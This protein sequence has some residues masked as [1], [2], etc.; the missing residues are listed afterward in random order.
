MS[1]A[2]ERISEL[3]VRLLKQEASEEEIAELESWKQA[4][5][6]NAAMLEAML[7]EG[8][9][10]NGLK[11]LETAQKRSTA[12]LA[13]A[14]ILLQDNNTGEAGT[15]SSTGETGT[16]STDER[17]G[18]S[19]Y[20]RK[21]VYNQ[22]RVRRINYRRW[23]AAA[24]VLMALAT[25]FYFWSQRYLRQIPELAGITP[26]STKAILT[27][28]DG[29]T[30]ALD[31]AG[32]QVIRQGSTAIRQQGGQLE[33]DVQGAS[34]TEHFNTLVTPRGGQF[35]VTLPDGSKVWLNAASSLRYPTAFINNTRT[36]EITGEAYF[37][38][39]QDAQKPFKVK[40]NNQT[41]ILVLGTEFNVNAYTDEPT[42]NTTLLEGAVRINTQTLTPGQQAQVNTDGAIKLIND[43]DV[44]ETVA[45][46]NGIFSFNNADVRT[47]MRQMGRWYNIEINY[48]QAVYTAKFKGKIDRTLDLTDALEVLKKAGVNF[49]MEGRTLTVMP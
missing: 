49:K 9:V 14:G 38:V 27:L 15:R 2:R 44:S 37:E 48:E 1:D 6:A 13:E 3:I 7:E 39:T 28:A 11:E 18:T 16:R 45:W 12:K 17:H 30:V 42:I 41:E 32:N 40:V 4:S 10:A 33:Y 46:K 29:S 31:S 36:V 23:V 20:N 22:S 34:K 21:T 5:A 35:R 8:Y 25:G 24:A 26:G 43:V 19:G 47:V